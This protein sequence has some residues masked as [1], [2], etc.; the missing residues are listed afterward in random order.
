MAE[1]Q[2]AKN[3]KQKPEPK[4]K[5]QRLVLAARAREPTHETD[6]KGSRKMPV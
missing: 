2:L 4:R 3:P 6:K 5:A 1:S